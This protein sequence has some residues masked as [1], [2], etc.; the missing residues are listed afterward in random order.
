MQFLFTLCN[1]NDAGQRSLEDV[2]GIFGHQLRALGH[3]AVWVPTQRDKFLTREA[4]I[5]VVVEGFTDWSVSWMSEA[6]GRGARFVILATEE[7]T[8]QGFNHGQSPEMIQRQKKF[9]EAARH[10]EAILHLVPGERVNAW[11]SQFAPSAYVEL[12]YAPSLV[13]SPDGKEPEY[14]YGFFGSLSRRRLKILRRLARTVPGH[15]KAVRIEATFPTQAERD[16]V[17]RQAKVIVQ[18]RK[19]DRMGLVSSSRCNTALH[20]GRPVVAEPHDL[21]RPWD[22]VIKFSPS[23]DAFYNDCLMARSAWRGVHAAQMAKFREKMS[24]EICVGRPLRQVGVLGSDG[25]RNAA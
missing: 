12:G 3:E 13:R 4:G 2:I 7:P 20:L 24:P 17:M 11:Y 14:D 19:D 8:D 10:A 15:Q 22:E 16:R 21:S 23:L 18:I 1:H 5:N 25:E 9:P 6:A